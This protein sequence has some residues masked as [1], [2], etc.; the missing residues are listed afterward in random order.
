MK[1]TPVLRPATVDDAAP[2][3]ETGRRTFI[4]TFVE[5]FGIPYPPADLER[6]MAA[7]FSVEAVSERLAD[8]AQAWWLA[9]AEGQV[10]AFANAGPNGLPHPEAHPG[11]TELKRLYVLGQAQGLGLGTRLLR[12]ALDWMNR[13]GTGD[14]WIG[15]WS[16]NLKAQ[17]LYRAHGFAKAGAYR[18]P[19]GDWLDDEFI[20]R[21]PVP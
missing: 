20:L 2:L 17:K 6:F 15:V 3:A 8:P 5:G 12:V 13:H 11:D 18:F 7:N 16:G 21:K 9:A 14:Q 1:V 4:E 19:V 10:L